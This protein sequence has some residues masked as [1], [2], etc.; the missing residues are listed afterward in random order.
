MKKIYLLEDAIISPLG[1][2]TEENLSAKMFWIF[3]QIFADIL[4]VLKGCFVFKC[5]FVIAISPQIFADL[6]IGL[7]RCFVI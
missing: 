7:K 3:P 4:I 2:S 6:G 5:R 1:F